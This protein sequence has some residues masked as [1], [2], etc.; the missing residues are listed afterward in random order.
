MRV[1]NIM[2]LVHLPESWELEKSLYIRPVE[3]RYTIP[4]N[5]NP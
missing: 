5:Q 3:H 1:E 2:V 4:R